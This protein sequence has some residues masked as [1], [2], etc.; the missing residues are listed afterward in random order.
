MSFDPCV[1]LWDARCV[2]QVEVLLMGTPLDKKIAS[3][4]DAVLL[5]PFAVL[6][7]RYAVYSQRGFLE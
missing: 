1:V 2:S 3:W 4:W 5:D 7:G 6:W